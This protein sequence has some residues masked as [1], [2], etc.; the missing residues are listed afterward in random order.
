MLLSC[1]IIIGCEND[2]L[3]KEVKNV[4]TGIVIEFD[5][6]LLLNKYDIIISVNGV[7]QGVQKQGE[8]LLYKL[9]LPEGKNTLSLS[10]F[11]KDDNNTSETFNVSEDNFYYFFIKTRNSGIR[12]EK[13]NVMTLNDVLLIVESPDIDTSSETSNNESPL[14]INKSNDNTVSSSPSPSSTPAPTP[15]ATPVPTPVP[16]PAPTPAPSPASTP[17]P[18]PAPTP[19]P[20]PIPIPTP[21]PPPH[22]PTPG[23]GPGPSPTPEPPQTPNPFPPEP[24]P[25]PTHSQP[26]FGSTIRP[27]LKSR[28]SR[29]HITV[30]LGQ[31]GFPGLAIASFDA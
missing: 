24:Q 10:Q 6:N 7:L 29:H 12:I 30:C 27:C 22:F 1:L 18:T 21:T 2:S 11:E 28:A 9:N 13:K 23:P 17:T 4:N 20:T 5:A 25:E 19:I 8:T 14:Y 16:A 26:L 31:P 15:S 3:D